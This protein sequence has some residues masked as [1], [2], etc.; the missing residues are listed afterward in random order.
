MKRPLTTL[1][2]AV[3]LVACLGATALFAVTPSPDRKQE[4]RNFDLR[5][6]YAH[7]ADGAASLLQSS[8]IDRLQASV[9]ELFADLDPATGATRSIFNRSGYLTGPDSRPARTVALD[10]VSKNLDLLG[11]SGDD[12]AGYE[13]T[14]D[15]YSAIDGST[16]L[17]LRQRHDGLP[18]YNGQL[19]VNVNRDGRI[20]SVNNLFLPQ[21]AASVNG[22]Q[23]SI[24]AAQALDAVAVHLGL[25]NAGAAQQIPVAPGT[26]QATRV[27][28]PELSLAPV[29]MALMWLPIRQGEARLVWNFRVD[30][31]DG[32]HWYS[33]NVDAHD[34]RIWTRLDF[35]A[36]AD[37]NVYPAPTE[38]PNHAAVVPP[39]DG[40]TLLTN[41]NNATASPFGWH[42]TNGVAGAE[43]TI[44]RG[45]NAHAYQ[46]TDGNDTPP[47]VQPDCGA[48]LDCEF[49]I[50][51]AGAPSTY[52]DAAIANLFYWNN[53]IH[54]IEFFYG[55]DSPGGNFQVNTYGLGG[56]GNDDV[57]A[58]AQSSGNCN[59]NFGTPADGSRPR[60][61]MF[62]C[63]NASPAHDG[64]FDAG[65]ITHEYGH[66][67]SN[68][69]VGGP[70]NVS[71]MGNSEQPGEGTSDWWGLS[72]TMD[73][74]DQG[75]DG[76][77]VG[78]YLLGQPITGNGVRTQRYSTDPAIN[79]FTY[80]SVPGSAIPHGVGEKWA[81]AYWEVT[82]A[83]I[84][85]H[86]FDSNLLNITHTA[87]DKGNVR[88]KFYINQGLKNTVCSP[89][90]VDVRNGILQ[91]AT[92]NYGGE[93]VCLIWEAFAAYGLGATASQGSSGS[94]T[95]Q[96][97]AFDIP[98]SCSFG[99]AGNDA[100]VCSTAGSHVQNISVGP[101]F[102]S[103]PVDMSA[104]GNPAGSTLLFS[105]DPVPSVPANITLTVGNLAAVAAGTYP[106]TVTADD[107]VDTF[108]D[109][110]SLTVDTAPAA[111]TTLTS[112]VDGA[113]GVA[114]SA[115]LAWTAVAG[116][117]S[118]DVEVDNNS[119]FSS[120]VYTATVSGTST[121]ATGLGADTVY[122]WR[123]KATNGCGG[124][125]T[126]AFDFR[127]TLEYCVSPA[128]PI[129][130]NG[131]AVTSNIVVPSG[132]PN[133]TDLNVKIVA[134]HTWVGDLKFSLSHDGGTAVML[135]DRPGVPTTTTGCASNDY[136]VI[137]NDEGTGNVETQCNAASP[138]VSGDRIGGDPAS[139]TLLQ[140]FDGVSI[141]GTWT[142]SA[143]DF[144]SIDTGTV[145]QWCLIPAVEIVDPTL[146][147]DGFESNDTS[148]WSSTVP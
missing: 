131:A 105:A 53:Y 67:I 44:M 33:F 50:N 31:L 20:L 89:G 77:G 115:P 60:M 26:Q 74:T 132:G 88:A 18:V 37:Y 92:D 15:V 145:N 39:T 114:T 17:Y 51:F 103:P 138:A 120:P 13:V 65:V 21:L 106:I 91:A 32:E 52:Q 101:A 135:I 11:I 139:T 80:A 100:R 30:T 40:R 70:A 133:V 2:F 124:T 58:Q 64:D 90:F 129:P 43:F 134:A 116:V 42:D 87:S 29:D 4:P 97:P 56:V 82:W 27:R 3:P 146:F 78:T 83:L 63:T 79:T 130:D 1:G 9:P 119:D 99:T 41:P 34:G 95:D 61:R 140:A 81:Q 16:H 35:I 110:F 108:N 143:Q 127:T 123:V 96:T 76:R 72:L 5:E 69:L 10:F 71:C 48:G 12:L 54:D 148:A 147:I 109:P 46:D 47:A 141:S 19:Q 23:P 36:D 125:F 25:P 113:N 66:G 121:V 128:L 73:A 7:A 117:T 59:A 85:A 104:T 22:R 137:I 118:Y 45:N 122:Y 6:A 49:T 142:L 55:F 136:D 75:T 126:G 93:D 24:D 14:D 144:A 8:A 57:Q 98:T 102:S 86:G 111:Q 28:V 38:S 62:T 107:G 68:R 94:I 84:D 112:P